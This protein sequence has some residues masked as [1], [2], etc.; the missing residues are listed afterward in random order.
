MKDALV[1]V[2]HGHMLSFVVCLSIIYF[3]FFRVHPSKHIFYFFLSLLFILFTFSTILKVVYATYP[4]WIMYWKKDY[5]YAAMV[6]FL[7]CAPSS[8]GILNFLKWYIPARENYPDRTKWITKSVTSFVAWATMRDW[9]CIRSNLCFLYVF[10]TNLKA[11]KH[12]IY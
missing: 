3:F 10:Y 1:H 8:S 5:M 12:T 2:N 7:S 9:S 4:W 6:S 11:I